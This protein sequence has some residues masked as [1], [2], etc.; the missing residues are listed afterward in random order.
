MPT[1]TED[2][3]ASRSFLRVARI[4]FEQWEEFGGG[5]TRLFDWLVDDRFTYIGRSTKGDEYR[6]H[7]VPR[8]VIRDI[9]IELYKA[10]RP[11]EA[12]AEVIRAMLKVARI[13]RDE[14][15]HLD[16]HLGLKSSMPEGWDYRSG[17]Y[18]A[19]LRAG[20]VEL[21][22]PLIASRVA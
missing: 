6:E 22:D 4:L 14:A 13:S 8:S 16:E 15:R 9:C 20:G 21:V 5:D 19:R 3:L 11:V 12:A 18:M 7:V 10:G 17:D 2:Q 1:F